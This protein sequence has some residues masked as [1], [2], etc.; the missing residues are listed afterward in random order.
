MARGA[1][2]RARIADAFRSTPAV[3]R[4]LVRLL[5]S[6]SVY[7]VI[8]FAMRPF[9]TRYA[10][11]PLRAA[12]AGALALSTLGAV[13]AI[14]RYLVEED[15]EYLR[16]RQTQAVLAATGLTLAAYTLWGDLAVFGLA[17]ELPAYDIFPVF[18]ASW[19]LATAV[20]RVLGR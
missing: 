13:W 2:V 18:S 12:L 10:S 6:L 5:G 20:R 4:Y 9:D 14:A 19:L 8:F 1:T 11:A 7:G 15:D 3:R 16:V 17:G